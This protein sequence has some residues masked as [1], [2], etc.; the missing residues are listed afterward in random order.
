MKKLSL[1]MVALVAT[2]MMANV[3]VSAQLN[4][5]I[6][7]DTTVWYNQTQQLGEVVVKSRLPRTKLKGNSIVTRIKG[8][9]LSQS[10]TAQEMLPT[11]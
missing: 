1:K 9:V 3:T 2:M 10:G 4:D 8:S 7:M 6:S 5:S 11:I